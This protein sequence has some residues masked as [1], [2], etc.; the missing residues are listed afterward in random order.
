M[1]TSRA[2]QRIPAHMYQHSI[3]Q[4]K[5]EHPKLGWMSV[6]KLWCF[7]P[8]EISDVTALRRTRMHSATGVD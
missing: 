8:K 2:F 6:D 1:T 7:F 4:K 5:L 3:C